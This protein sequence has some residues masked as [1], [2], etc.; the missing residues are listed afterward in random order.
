[1]TGT[2]WSRTVAGP[3]IHSTVP[4]ACEPASRSIWAP[5]AAITTGTRPGDGV[6]SPMFARTVVPVKAAGSPPSSGSRT[7]RYSF[8]CRIGL[9]KS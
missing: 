7:A 2:M 1:M 3:V 5:S 6:V 9:L 8:M 4:S